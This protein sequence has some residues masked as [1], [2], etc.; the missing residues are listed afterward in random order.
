MSGLGM[1]L[2]HWSY[3]KMIELGFQE[4]SQEN[5]YARH[6]IEIGFYGFPKV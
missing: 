2:N 5:M 1:R 6:E 3:L 4:F